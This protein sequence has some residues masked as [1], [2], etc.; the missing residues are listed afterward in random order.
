M[1]FLVICMSVIAWLAFGFSFYLK[2]AKED[3]ASGHTFE[4]DWEIFLIVL[5]TGVLSYVVYGVLLFAEKFEDFMN[6]S[7]NNMNGDDFK[8]YQNCCKKC[9]SVSLH[10]EA[11]GNN[12]GLY[13][14]DCG[15]WQKWLNKDELRAFLHS[16]REAT[17][18]ERESVSEHIESISKPTGDNF[19]D[20]KTVIERLTEFKKHLDNEIDAEMEKF[21]VSPEDAVRKNTYCF[22][23][24]KVIYSIENIIAGRDFNDAGE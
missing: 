5:A 8:G 19:Y 23:L 6:K 12:T 4:F 2:L 21:P 13:C 15:S 16:M 1:V 17:P 10:T 3:I 9:G 24:Q 11:K 20:D 18:E 22:G 7:I 14:D